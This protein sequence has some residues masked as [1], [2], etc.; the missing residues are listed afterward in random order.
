VATGAVYGFGD[1]C[2]FFAWDR[3][4]YGGL[5][6]GATADRRTGP[7]RVEALRSV[8]VRSL[9]GSSGHIVIATNAETGKEEF[10]TWGRT[11]VYNSEDIAVDL[12]EPRRFELPSTTATR[13]ATCSLESTA[14]AF[15]DFYRRA[16]TTTAS[17]T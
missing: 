17:T 12:L 16:P 2:E 4:I 5:A 10:Y 15:V 11:C 1:K 14:S 8:N 13:A 3:G 7:G 9:C 6:S